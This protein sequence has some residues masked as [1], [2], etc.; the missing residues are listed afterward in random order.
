MDIRFIWNTRLLLNVYPPHRQAYELLVRCA[1]SQQSTSNLTIVV[2]D[3]PITYGNRA[4]VSLSGQQYSISVR[5]H[6]QRPC[7]GLIP[8]PNS[9]EIPALPFVKSRQPVGN[10]V[11]NSLR[12]LSSRIIISQD[13][14]V[15]LGRRYLSH[16]LPPLRRPLPSSPEEC[17]Q[18]T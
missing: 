2:F 14:V 6:I 1:L 16:R 11:D 4:F 3:T 7:H 18:P 13:G 10:L 15:R 8:I 5:C 9:D 12:V 17:D